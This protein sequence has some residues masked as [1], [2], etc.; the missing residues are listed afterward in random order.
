METAQKRSFQVPRDGDRHGVHRNV[1]IG[2]LSFKVTTADSNGTILVAEIAHHAKGGP[3]RH[4]HLDQDEWFHVIEG[5]YI[6]EMGDERYLLAPGDSAYGPGGVPRESDKI[7]TR[8]PKGMRADLAK[9]ATQR[10]RSANAEV[11]RALTH[12]LSFEAG[13]KP[14]VADDGFYVLTEQGLVQVSK[15]LEANV[16]ALEEL[17]F[18][19]RDRRAAPR[20]AQPEPITDWKGF[21]RLSLVTC[22][23]R[24]YPAT[25]DAEPV[26]YPPGELSKEE[27]D[28][29]A[30]ELTHTIEIDEF[31]PKTEIDNRYLIRPYYLVPDGKVGHDAFAVIRESIRAT[32]KVAIARVV[33]ANREHV[34][35][36]EPLDKGM[37]GTL[38]RYPDELR[39]EK[40]YFEIVQDVRVTE[41]MIDLAKHIVEQK[42]GSFDPSKF[43][44]HY[45]AALTEL[46]KNKRS[47]VK[48][49][50]K[51]T[52][53]SSGNV[54]NLMDALKKS[55]RAA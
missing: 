51:A 31:V 17:V 18:E 46:I 27:L 7:I 38:L 19:L 25:S 29:I 47:G 5:K 34:I 11:V 53:K 37:V 32:N 2:I 45:Q 48:I 6:V 9:L 28:E 43:E 22:P 30:L 44:D 35:A 23:I 50:P 13:V 26:T 21:L 49:E 24:L 1:G 52:S 54:I 12:Y 3:P 4:L 36:I 15:R 42:S 8:L 20:S 14:A 55:V 10:E 16:Q 39:S 40:D 41:D 33:L